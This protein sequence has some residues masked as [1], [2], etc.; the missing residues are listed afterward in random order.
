[1]TYF[2]TAAAQRNPA[3]LSAPPG[4]APS[5]RGESSGETAPHYASLLRAALLAPSGHNTQSW[6]FR[7]HSTGIDILPDLSRRTPVVDPDDHHLYASLGCAAENIMVAAEI[8]GFRGTCQYDPEADTATISFSRNST[9]SVPPATTRERFQAIPRRQCTRGEYLPSFPS[10]DDLQ[11]LQAAGSGPGVHLQLFTEE[12]DRERALEY[13][14]EGNTR[15]ITNPAF[16]RELEE[17]IR[18]SD[19]EAIRTGDGLPARVTGNPPVPRWIGTPIFRFLF[20]PSRESDRLARQIRS[21]WGVALFSCDTDDPS[22]WI[23]A[24]RCYQRFALAATTRGISSAFINQPLEERALRPSLRQDFSA[25]GIRP[26]F[27]LRFGRARP[28]PFSLRR[29][30]ESLLLPPEPER[31]PEPA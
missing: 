25:P 31:P 17:W 14:I 26:N 7:T 8:Q 29:P 27:L 12:T 9:N 15:Q 13:V 24:G 10:P 6:K 21:S 3:L 30:L 28:V 1:M 5:S 20:T 19:R 11:V 18:F 16:C 23:E 22:G 4:G 2:E